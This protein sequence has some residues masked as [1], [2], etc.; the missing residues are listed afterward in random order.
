MLD[1][2]LFQSNGNLTLGAMGLEIKRWGNE[3]PFSVPANTY[4]CR[5]GLVMAGVLLDTHWKVL[6]RMAG[7]HDLADPTT[8]RRCRAA[9]AIAKSATRCSPEW[10]ATRPS[11]KPS[12][13]A[14]KRESRARKVRTYAEAAR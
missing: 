10:C 13:S 5:D 6:A 1:A 9:W 2:M 8:S 14:R 7:R 12:M 3:F 4:Q 11:M